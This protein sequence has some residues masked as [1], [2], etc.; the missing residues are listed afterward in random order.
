MES[1][2]S[3]WR[4]DG[5]TDLA[6][7]LAVLPTSE[8]HLSVALRAC[9]AL[10]YQ[11]MVAIDYIDEAQ[12]HLMD[13]RGCKSLQVAPKYLLLSNRQRIVKKRH[14]FEEKRKKIIKKNKGTVP[15]L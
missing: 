9:S 1:V 11:G 5:V 14:N 12:I 3:L 4:T 15:W 2:L 7:H 13:K 8:L 6:S 10:Q